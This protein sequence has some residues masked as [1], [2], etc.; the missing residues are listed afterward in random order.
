MGH[1]VVRNRLLYWALLASLTLHLLLVTLIPPLANL[2]GAQN[3][4]LLSF[5]R[6]QP[7]HIQTPRPHVEHAA[8]APVRAPAAHVAVAH[9]QARASRPIARTTASAQPRPEMAAPVVGAVKSGAAATSAGVV[10]SNVST[11][12]SE[13]PLPVPSEGPSR[14]VVGGFMPLGAEEPIP[15]L[16]PSVQ[17]ALLAL[18][19]HVT[20][21]ITV[22][23]AGHTRSVAFQP[24][25]ADDIEKQ[26]RSLLASASW[27]PAVCG[28]GMTC[29]G[30]A[31]IKL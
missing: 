14:Q 30:Q 5:V 2:E 26:I 15:V 25:L 21:T 13:T 3:I 12:P 17:K 24:P 29:E 9:A 28:G 1:A 4:E 8:S 22:D 31:T 19:V 20:L 23:A 16:D 6:I 10:A 18:G 7:V 11:A 27:D